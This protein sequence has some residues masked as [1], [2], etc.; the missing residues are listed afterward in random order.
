MNFYKILKNSTFLN[1]GFSTITLR[2]IGVALSFSMLLIVTNLFTDEIVGKYQYLNSIIIVAGTVALLGSNVSFI[3]FAGEIWAEGQYDSLNS[4]YIRNFVIVLSMTVFFILLYL[5]MRMQLMP[6]YI[7]AQDDQIYIFSLLALF[8]NCIA[9]LNFQVL[10]SFRRLYLSEIFRNVVKLCLIILCILLFY[11]LGSKTSL[12]EAYVLSLWL[13]AVLSTWYVW[14]ELHRLPQQTKEVMGDVITY[15]K[16]L[17]VSIPMTLSFL[18]LLLMQQ[19]DLILLKEYSAYENLAYYGVAVK[20][21][22]MLNIALVAVN[23]VVGP[24]LAEFYYKKDKKGLKDIVEKSII[25]NTALSLPVM[26]IVLMMPETILSVFGSNYILAK[27]AL[28]ILL[29]GQALNA[30]MGSTD[31]YLNMTGKQNYFQKIIFIALII[32]VILNFVLIP[33]FGMIGAAIATAIS[34]VFW[35]ILGVIYIYRVDNIILIINF[36]LIKKYIFKK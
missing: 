7:S 12:L 17:R 30:M 23:Q 22:M 24:Q 36:A 16:I 11:Y 5:I 31:L 19:L 14:K 8:P 32:N 27:D 34:L 26:I 2:G 10:L 3:R 29:I 21:S 20:I 6:Q 28:I 13:V 35:N 25:L 15:R 4:L 1:R 18:S 33:Q 9:I